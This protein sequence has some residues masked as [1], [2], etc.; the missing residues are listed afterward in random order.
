MIYTS[1]TVFEFHEE[2]LSFKPGFQT[3]TINLHQYKFPI[4]QE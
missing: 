1:K 3:Q 2:K 4:R